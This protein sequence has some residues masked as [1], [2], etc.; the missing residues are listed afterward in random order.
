MK[1]GCRLADWLAGSASS[2]ASAARCVW[3]RNLT[4]RR[5]A[6][7]PTTS[8]RDRDVRRNRFRAPSVPCLPVPSGVENAGGPTRPTHKHTAGGFGP[9]QI[10]AA[11]T[12]SFTF[13]RPKVYQ[14]FRRRL[15][16]QDRIRELE[17]S[18]TRSW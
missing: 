11:D 15:V 14:L 10:A 1:T 3:L 4:D 6:A 8:C 5:P 2:T 12:N 17:G 16:Q 13:R 18:A 7:S 9:P